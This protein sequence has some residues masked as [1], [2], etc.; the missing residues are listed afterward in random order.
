[1]AF[2]TRKRRAC[3]AALD[4]ER[5]FAR[6]QQKY[7]VGGRGA[8]A[9]ADASALFPEARRDR[10]AHRRHCARLQQHARGRHQQSAAFE[11]PA[12]ARRRGF[13]E[14][15]RRRDRSRA[16]RGRAGAAP[17]RLREATAVR[18]ADHRLQQPRRRNVGTAAAH[19][20][21]RDRIRNHSR[22]GTMAH[23]GRR[24]SARKRAAQSRAQRA[25]CDAERRQDHHRDGQHLS[26][27]RLRRRAHRNES[28][29]DMCSSPSPTRAAA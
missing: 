1:M 15:R 9:A 28:R 3:R 7:K 10:T 21:R 11:A 14:I 22:G 16:Q 5:G 17:A 20:R 24:A 23:A 12:G 2:A 29:P 8:G 13:R 6:R 27:R 19:A 4:D 26:R 25:R 18:A